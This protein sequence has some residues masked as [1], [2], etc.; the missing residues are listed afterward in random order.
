M[1]YQFMY[2]AWDLLKAFTYVNKWVKI[3]VVGG[4]GGGGGSSPLSGSI[5]EIVNSVGQGIS[6]THGGSNHEYPT[7]N[8]LRDRSSDFTLYRLKSYQLSLS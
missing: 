4:G 8:V 2:T 1:N 5:C 3:M 7:R 6:E